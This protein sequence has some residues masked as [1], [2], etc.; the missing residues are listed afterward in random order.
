[1]DQEIHQELFFVRTFT[2][3]TE[4]ESIFNVLKDYFMEEAIPL[5]NIILLATDGAPAM[6]GCYCG[7]EWKIASI[8]SIC[9]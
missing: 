6:V 3:D 1:M 5:S 7:F 9:H 2:M 8:S 4:G